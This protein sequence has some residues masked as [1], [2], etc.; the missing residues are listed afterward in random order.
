MHNQICIQF[1]CL[2]KQNN[3]FLSAH[4]VFHSSSNKEGCFSQSGNHRCWLKSVKHVLMA[5]NKPCRTQ[6]CS[7]AFDEPFELVCLKE[8]IHICHLS[9]AVRKRETKAW[10]A[11]LSEGAKPTV[12]SREH[13]RASYFNAANTRDHKTKIVRLPVVYLSV[14]YFLL[15]LIVGRSE[16]KVDARLP[17]CYAAINK[18]IKVARVTVIRDLWR[19]WSLHDGDLI[20]LVSTRM[21]FKGGINRLTSTGS[22]KQVYLSLFIELLDMINSIMVWWVFR[23]LW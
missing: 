19:N 17:K 9:R 14:Y 7:C 8:M 20:I 15:W 12:Q 18:Q 21:R 10:A 16:W 6:V 23:A 2:L 5:E 11:S 22:K 13:E 1:P 3:L 4:E